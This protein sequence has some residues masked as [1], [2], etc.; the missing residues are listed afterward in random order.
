MNGR[1]GLTLVFVFILRLK[2]E[3]HSIE[4]MHFRSV[5]SLGL[6]WHRHFSQPRELQKGT[7]FSTDYVSRHFE[8]RLNASRPSIS[9]DVFIG[10]INRCCKR[11]PRGNTDKQ[12]KTL[13]QTMNFKPL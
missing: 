9:I 5:Q 12:R 7:F 2:F 3:F 8:C 6:N 4:T 11:T 10:A 13:K 1:G